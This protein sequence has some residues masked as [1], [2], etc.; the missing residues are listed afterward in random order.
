MDQFHNSFLLLIISFIVRIVHGFAS[1]ITA[2]LSKIK[3]KK[4]VYS[5]GATFV[6]EEEFMYT[7][8]FL[9]LGWSNF[10]LC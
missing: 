7:L 8:G 1:A 3:I 4:L 10:F 2:I 5:L 9:E 6:T